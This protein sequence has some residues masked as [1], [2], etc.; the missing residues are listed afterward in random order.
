[1]ATLPASPGTP[2]GQP[3]ASVATGAAQ[4][5]AAT[6]KPAVT[7]VAQ[8]VHRAVD[9]TPVARTVTK[10]FATAPIPTRS[11]GAGSGA[12][13]PAGVPST[14]LSATGGSSP[15]VKSITNKIAAS[16]GTLLAHR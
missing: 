7:Q 10:V 16:V 1:L 6:V 2:L 3:G 13:A 5:A 12:G 9:Q 11:G 4:R 14:P 15:G 8:T